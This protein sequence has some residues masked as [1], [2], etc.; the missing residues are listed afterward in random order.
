M[1]NHF[2]EHFQG[3][4]HS[5][6]VNHF[7]SMNEHPRCGAWIHSNTHTHQ[8]KHIHASYLFKFSKQPFEKNIHAHLKDE[9]TDTQRLDCAKKN[10]FSEKSI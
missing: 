8:R 2:E 7:P 3:L 9:K 5:S 1:N 4:R 10:I 6:V